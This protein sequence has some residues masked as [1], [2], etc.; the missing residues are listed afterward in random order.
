MKYISYKEG[1]ETTLN[2]DYKKLL[3]VAFV[4][5]DCDACNSFFDLVCP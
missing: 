3:C 2:W 4:E 1:V 5:Q